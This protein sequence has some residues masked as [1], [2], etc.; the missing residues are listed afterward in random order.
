[1]TLRETQFPSH[2]LPDEMI[3]NKDDAVNGEH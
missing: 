3:V 2:I 1:M